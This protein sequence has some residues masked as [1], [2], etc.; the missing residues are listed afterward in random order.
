MQYRPGKVEYRFTLIELLVV[1]AIIAIL[2][3]LLLP[4]LGKAREKARRIACA[5][6]LRQIGIATALYHDDSASALL[7][8]ANTKYGWYHDNYTVQALYADYLNGSLNGQSTVANA[9]RYDPSPV[10][11]CP[12][13]R[14]DSYRPGSYGQYAGGAAD[15]RMTHDSLKSFLDKT[16]AALSYVYSDNVA[17]WGDRCVKSNTAIAITGGTESTNHSAADGSPDGGNVVHIDG[18]VS[19]YD[20]IANEP[21]YYY[22][23]GGI[24]ADISIPTSSI[25]PYT[26]GYNLDGSR[27]MFTGSTWVDIP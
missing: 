26:S 17:L 15:Y 14:R 24:N 23:N 19:W 3:S 7:V 20:F 18:S 27:K 22:G 12:S 16:A 21:G 9:L 25:F 10:F 1:I 4:A 5:S 6:N 8:N 13:A 11:I 2:A